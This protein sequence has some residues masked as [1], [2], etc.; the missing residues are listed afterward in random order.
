MT[1][2]LSPTLKIGLQTLMRRPEPPTG[3]WQPRTQ[4]IRDLVQLLDRLGYDSLFC[5]DHLAY[6][7]PL[8]DPF[9]QL[10]Q[11]AALSDRLLVGT[12]IYLLPL[13]HPSGAAKQAASLDVLS[14][15]R[16][17]MGVGVGGEFPNEFALAGVPRE[18]RGA[19]LTEGIEVMRK[20][21]SGET[22]NN[23]DGRF[24]PF[25]DVQML[26][27]P[28]DP[29]GPPVWCGGRQPGALKRAARLADGYVSYVITPEMF[30]D[31]LTMIEDEHGKAGR[32]DPFDTAHL[33]F[34]RIGDSYEQAFDTANAALSLRYA[35]DF[36]KPTKRY[37]AIGTAEQVAERIRAFYD[38]GVR[39]VVLDFCG[40]Y[41]LEDRA[42]Q[43]TRFAEQVRPLLPK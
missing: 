35:M 2:P 21:W 13:R 16:F 7:V 23:L 43:L 40:P 33:L 19:R 28:I 3:P 12:C 9:V 8:L 15:G 4:E 24:Y 25:P 5:G 31:A 42:D 32:T 18:E 29:K 10:A 14:G 41:S 1:L 39:H 26:P 36:T 27:T 6:A 30:A 22:V 38:A 11:A 20:L 17:I 34:L 37:A